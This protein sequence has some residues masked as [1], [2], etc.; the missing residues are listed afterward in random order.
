[1]SDIEFNNFTKKFGG[2]YTRKNLIRNYIDHPEWE[3]RLR[4]LFGIETEE[5]RKTKSIIESTKIAKSAKLISLF[6]TVIAL[7]SLIISIFY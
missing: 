2:D 1:M 4:Q 3:P 6:S 7:I 5:E